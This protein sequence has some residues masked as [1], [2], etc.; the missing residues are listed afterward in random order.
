MDMSEAEMRFIVSSILAH[1]LGVRLDLSDADMTEEFAKAMA[2]MLAVEQGD[3]KA[4]LLMM[5][6]SERISAS[7]KAIIDGRA[8]K[9]IN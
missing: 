3:A 1:N 7:V 8:A 5:A 4:S 2:T 9:T 6:A